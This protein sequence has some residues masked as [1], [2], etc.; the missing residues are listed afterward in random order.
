MIRAF[1]TLVHIVSS[2]DAAIVRRMRA[3]VTKHR[4]VE[5][6]CV[7]TLEEEKLHPKVTGA[8]RARSDA[9][10]PRKRVYRKRALSDVPSPLFHHHSR[11]DA[12]AP[13]R[14]FG[15]SRG[16]VPSL[17]ELPTLSMQ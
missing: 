17:G 2:L 16:T 3:A 10:Q 6:S 5:W 12:L 11:N 7:I 13:T 9:A 8:R 1:L 14:D 15:S 4:V